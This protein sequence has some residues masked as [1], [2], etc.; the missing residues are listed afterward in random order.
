MKARIIGTGSYLPE[1]VLTNFDL[2][3][4]VET[5]NDW[6]VARTGIE[7]RH[8][9]AEGQTTSDMAT[10]ALHGK[11]WLWLELLLMKSI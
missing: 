10:E 3:E 4:M 5:S 2:E 6:I 9:A 1:K 7:E 11:L 8:I